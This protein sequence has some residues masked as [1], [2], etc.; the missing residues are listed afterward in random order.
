M[1]AKCYVVQARDST[2]EVE[3]L[4][5]T[6]TEYKARQKSLA[7]EYAE[8][9]K[10]YRKL[11]SQARKNGE[12]LDNVSVPKKP[13]FR[14]LKTVR[15]V[16]TAKKY[17]AQYKKRWDAKRSKGVRV[18]DDGASN[19]TKYHV[20]KITDSSGKVSYSAKNSSD[21]KQWE[22]DKARMHALAFSKWQRSKDEAISAGNKFTEKKPKEPK[23]LT[24]KIVATEEQ[25]ESEAERRQKKWD[26][27]RK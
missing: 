14:R 26:N 10:Q 5:L 23:L 17:A 6:S 3:F 21:L 20:V 19:T 1:T 18:A 2:G 8:A 9:V 24:I 13:L 11:K 4:A 22:M 15:G 25:A 12:K 7:R 27:R 16:P